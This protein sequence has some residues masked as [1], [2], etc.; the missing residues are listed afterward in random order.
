MDNY[1]PRQNTRMRWKD[2]RELEKVVAGSSNKRITVLNLGHSTKLT[3]SAPHW[4]ITT[5]EHRDSMRNLNSVDVLVYPQNNKKIQE[6][7]RVSTEN[8]D[9]NLFITYFY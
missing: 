4:T 2:E 5:K 3:I 7:L 9:K 8:K 1:N 6:A